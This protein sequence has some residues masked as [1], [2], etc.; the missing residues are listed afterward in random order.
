[1]DVKSE[2]ARRSV[3]LRDE[4]S[5]AQVAQ[6]AASLE[7][8]MARDANYVVIEFQVAETKSKMEAAM[9]AL[10]QAQAELKVGEKSLLNVEAMKKAAD[11]DEERWSMWGE[12]VDAAR[13]K[14]EREE[15][16]QVK[17]SKYD[18]L[19]TTTNLRMHRYKSQR[20]YDRREKV[21]ELV[22][23]CPQNL[24]Y[25]KV[26]EQHAAGEVRVREAAA[27][28]FRVEAKRAAHDA[29][30]AAGELAAA[31][32]RRLKL[33]AKGG[34]SQLL[35]T[36]KLAEAAQIATGQ[37]DCAQA[38]DRRALAK[39]ELQQAESEAAAAGGASAA[40]ALALALAAA[41]AAEAA[42]AAEEAPAAAEGDDSK[43]K[44]RRQAGV[45]KRKCGH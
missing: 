31:K 30:T 2:E 35:D 33:G 9:N 39:K 29:A 19:T 26:V 20:E 32:R 13:N 1:M 21:T 8:V 22:Q 36:S 43:S 27:S 41:L 7:W 40:S 5:A 11:D 6:S 18:M 12:N 25:A 42:A 16:E 10:A 34:K 23:K 17:A 37:A 3:A 14:R 24:E 15:K 45:A 28:S 4:V 44:P 38:Q